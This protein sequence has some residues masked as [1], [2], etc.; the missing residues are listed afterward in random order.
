MIDSF[1]TMFDRNMITTDQWIL[2]IEKNGTR[3]QFAK[4][5]KESGPKEI[6]FISQEKKLSPPQVFLRNA[7]T[8]VFATL[9]Q[10]Q[11]L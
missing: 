1:C 2:D 10:P 6:I 9:N 7:E 5:A 11:N 3:L 4:V 8:G